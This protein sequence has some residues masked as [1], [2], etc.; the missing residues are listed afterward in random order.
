M[1]KVVRIREVVEKVSKL[2]REEIARVNDLSDELNAISLELNKHE[3]DGG[4]NV[5]VAEYEN[6]KIKKHTLK[7]N[8]ELQEKY[9]DGIFDSR[10]LL[11]DLGLD[12]IVDM[13]EHIKE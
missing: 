3:K 12:T 10:E 1:A 7:R 5:T 4:K 8:K 11:M 9:C 2:Y 6:L 13:D